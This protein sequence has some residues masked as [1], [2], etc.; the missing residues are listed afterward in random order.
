MGSCGVVAV[1]VVNI[2]LAVGGVKSIYDMISLPGNWTMPALAMQ[3]QNPALEG[4]VAD[5]MKSELLPVQDKG[6]T[7]LPNL[8]VNRRRD[9]TSPERFMFLVH[10]K[11]G[12]TSVTA[13]LKK[14]CPL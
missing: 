12:S 5:D 9:D 6:M 1:S 10:S 4:V 8:F 3:R 2:I 14:I 7:F 11:S 13:M